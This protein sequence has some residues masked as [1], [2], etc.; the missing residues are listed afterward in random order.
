MKDAHQIL[1]NIFFWIIFILSP[2]VF[3]VL[4][5]IPFIPEWEHDW[6]FYVWIYVGIVYSVVFIIFLF[7]PQY[8]L[9]YKFLVCSGII[10]LFAFHF[11]VFFIID[12]K[13]HVRQ[14]SIDFKTKINEKT[15]YLNNHSSFGHLQHELGIRKNILPLYSKI[16][17][18]ESNTYL[19][20]YRIENHSVLFKEYIIGV[21]SDDDETL[22]ASKTFLEQLFDIFTKRKYKYRKIYTRQIYL[23]TEENRISKE[24]VFTDT[25]NIP[26]KTDKIN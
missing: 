6:I 26:D 24:Q 13:Y 3:Y 5:L 21:Y 22:G 17:E 19:E 16:Y 4:P 15:V 8:N 7:K 25:L 18:T 14:G 9:F 1:S 10:F 23:D 11:I 20:F 2:M 12:Y